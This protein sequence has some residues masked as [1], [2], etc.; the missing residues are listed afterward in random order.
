MLRYKVT[1]TILLTCLFLLLPTGFSFKRV[2]YKN[3]R[4]TNVCKKLKGEALVYF[5]FVDSRKTAPW[6]EF[7]IQSTL[8]S[9]Q[10]AV[11][12]IE[13]QAN[14]NGIDLNIK[15][16][17][18][19]GDEYA[20]ISKNLPNGTVRNSALE[21]KFKH[22]LASLNKWADYIAKKAGT[23]FYIANK[24][25]IPE[26]KNPR[27]KERLVAFLRDENNVESV[28]LLYMV[29]NYFRDD[30]S[31]PVNFMDTRDV[32]FAIVS[33]KYPSIIAHN[34]LHMFGAVDLY[35]TPYRRH[36]NK[37]EDLKSL[38]PNSVMQDVYARNLKTLRMDQ[39]TKYMIGWTNQLNPELEPYLMD[40]IKN[41]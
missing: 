35:E 33:Y 27:N 5:I 30:I 24:D 17:Y 26:I 19:I 10:V 34:I 7:D 15:T 31:I 2:N 41:F 40:K 22:G 23:S 36:E 28:A 3:A 11:Q 32:E 38:F 20:T 9:M 14:E 13:R 1:I 39:Y 8:D 25:G 18:F 37:I 4:S 16:D 29:N 12:W 6:T 21:P